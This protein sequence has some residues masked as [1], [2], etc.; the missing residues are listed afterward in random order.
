MTLIFDIY[1]ATW[2]LVFKKTMHFMVQ[3]IPTYH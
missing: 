2:L 3:I 1:L